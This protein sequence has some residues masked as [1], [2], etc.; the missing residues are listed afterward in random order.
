MLRSEE[1]RVVLSRG[2]SVL[3]QCD[4][5]L[6]QSPTAW[7]ND[8]L[9]SFYLGHLQ[10]AC[11]ERVLLVDCS[12][13]YFL[14]VVEQ[15]DAGVV[16]APLRLEERGLVLF[17]VNDNSDVTAA[18]GGSHWTLLSKRGAAFTHYDS[19][20]CSANAEAALRIAQTLGGPG[21]RV[22]R[23]ATPRQANGSDCGL[24]VCLAAKLLCEA[25]RRTRADPTPAELMGLTPVA[26]A[27]LR[28][29][30]AAL[31]QRLAEEDE[32]PSFDD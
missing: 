27:A 19:L 7:L 31:I 14:S 17:A 3:R 26:A 4:V 11:N 20:G 6:L 23:A 8:A 21:A 13:S 22:V 12:A 9:L 32:G 5:S 2:D 15:E 24:H 10:E 16:T 25:Q 29:E 28:G 30:L 18:N 1:E